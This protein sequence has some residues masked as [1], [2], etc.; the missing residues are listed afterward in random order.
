MIDSTVSADIAAAR[1]VIEKI[2]AV[3]RAGRTLAGAM[4]QVAL[5]EAER[6]ELQVSYLRLQKELFA[7]VRAARAAAGEPGGL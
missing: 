2:E 4:R 6:D 7:A 1:E 5:A 3:A